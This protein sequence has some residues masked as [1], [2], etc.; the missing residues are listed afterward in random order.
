M[1]VLIYLRIN[2]FPLNFVDINLTI[3][4]ATIKYGKRDQSGKIFVPQLVGCLSLNV[5][6]V[7]EPKKDIIS[8]G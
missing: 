6:E 7:L 1:H 2:P 3:V 5:Q 8:Y 4:L